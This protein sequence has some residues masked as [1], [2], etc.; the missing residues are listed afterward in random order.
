MP[1]VAEALPSPLSEIQGAENGEE[2]PGAT[3]EDLGLSRAETEAQ[4]D[5]QSQEL[6]T[7]SRTII[8]R[9]ASEARGE[10]IGKTKEENNAFQAANPGKAAL[11]E[12]HSVENKT[13][14][15]G[16]KPPRLIGG[17]YITRLIPLGDG[18]FSY[19]YKTDLASDI[20][21]SRDERPESEGG[22]PLF[23]RDQLQIEILLQEADNIEN[24]LPEGQ[25]ELFRTHVAILRDGNAALEDK[26]PEELNGLTDQG[27]K[28][29]NLL[30]NKA[31]LSFAGNHLTPEQLPEVVSLLSQGRLAS[32]EGIIKILEMGGIEQLALESEQTKDIKE[33]EQRLQYGNLDGPTRKAY[34]RDLAVAR[35]YKIFFNQVK[36][37]L[38]DET[39]RQEL[40]GKITTGLVDPDRAKAVMTALESGKMEEVVKV[41]FNDDPNDTPKERAEKKLKQ[42]YA[43]KRMKMIKGAGLLALL[44]VIMAGVELQKPL[45]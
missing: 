15:F 14:S 38:S 37:M 11:I 29:A 28:D 24:L 35:E 31:L 42:E 21:P 36:D 5:T 34:E 39:K 22:D 6:Q 26:T 8:Y 12:M 19:Q 16:L 41:L 30:T 10:A 43:A 40:V 2:P 23:T 3:P 18:T 4:R 25:R 9:Q 1:E 27:A 33:L 44:M 20:E 32:A 17:R 13:D 45:R 7:V